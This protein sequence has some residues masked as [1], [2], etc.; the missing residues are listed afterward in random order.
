MLTQEMR[1]PL[2]FSVMKKDVESVRLFLRY[3]A[4]LDHI[5]TNGKSLLDYAFESY[6]LDIV[7]LLVRHGVTL[8]KEGARGKELLLSATMAN[9]ALLIKY[10]VERDVPLTAQDPSVT[11]PNQQTV[12]G[13][14][15]YGGALDGKYFALHDAA[16]LP[17]R[18]LCSESPGQERPNSP[19]ASCQSRE[20]RSRQGSSQTRRSR[21]Q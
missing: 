15:V 6:D 8:G 1:T 18:L 13:D 10:L 9:D 17:E 12:R 7:K 3:R 11:L 14:R 20:R 2:F 5:D 21:S 16:Q 4:S 19:D